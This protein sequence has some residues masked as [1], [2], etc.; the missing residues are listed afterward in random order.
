MEVFI[1]KECRDREPCIGNTTGESCEDAKWTK[2]ND[3][4]ITKKKDSFKFFGKKAS[5][6]ILQGNHLYS[7]DCK[8]NLREFESMESTEP[9]V[10]FVSDNDGLK[11]YSKKYL[12]LIV[13]NCS[14]CKWNREESRNTGR[15]GKNKK[16]DK[17]IIQT[18]TAQGNRLTKVCYNSD[19]CKALYEEIE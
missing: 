3:Y 7:V 8:G 12:D 5:R 18:C 6:D 19:E 1:C 2:T 9:E 13:P 10:I 4:E 14:L 11:S 15:Q 16:P 17:K